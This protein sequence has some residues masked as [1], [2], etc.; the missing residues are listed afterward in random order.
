MALLTVTGIIRPVRERQTE[1]IKLMHCSH[2]PC[3]SWVL[4]T[5]S[6]Q[7]IRFFF[8]CLYTRPHSAFSRA[9]SSSRLECLSIE[10]IYC[11]I[12]YCI[13]IRNCA[14]L[15][16]VLSHKSPRKEKCFWVLLWVKLCRS[17]SEHPKLFL[18]H[19][20]NGSS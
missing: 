1:L 3:H 19:E 10:D 7:S 14:T 12:M 9:T 2:W 8:H 20:A 13:F 6:F 11:N 15:D 5:F 18:L 16:Q 17:P 4:P